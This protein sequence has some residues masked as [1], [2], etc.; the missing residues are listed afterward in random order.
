MRFFY[1]LIFLNTLVFSALAQ[2]N[3]RGKVVDQDENPIPFVKVQE[4]ET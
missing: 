1:L 4:P 2:K 3:T